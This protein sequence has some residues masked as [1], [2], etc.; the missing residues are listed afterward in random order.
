MSGPEWPDIIVA[1]TAVYAAIISTYNLYSRYSD[2]R[3]KITVELNYGVTKQ[4]P[5]VYKSYGINVKNL[6][7]TPI[8]LNSVCIELPDNKKIHLMQPLREGRLP[9]ELKPGSSFTVDY[10]FSDLNQT[11]IEEG[12][13]NLKEFRAYYTDQ[14]DNKYYSKKIIRLDGE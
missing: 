4:G 5:I 1:L 6:G 14:L 11:L 10:P 12:I 3:Q 2:Q 9:C 8:I 13:T 7:K